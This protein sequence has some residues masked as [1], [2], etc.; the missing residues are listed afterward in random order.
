LGRESV[1]PASELLAVR[2]RNVPAKT[3][4]NRLPRHKGKLRAEVHAKIDK[5]RYGNELRLTTVHTLRG[6]CGFVTQP[7]QKARKAGCHFGKVSR[8]IKHEDHKAHQDK[9]ESEGII[10]QVFLRVL[11]GLDV[12]PACGEDA[13]SAGRFPGILDPEATLCASP[14]RTVDC[15]NLTL[16]AQ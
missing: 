8:E 12:Y 4:H 13:R 14:G 2:K 16:G 1:P 7:R 10:L 5:F 11:C 3:A 15:V 9:Q 6:L